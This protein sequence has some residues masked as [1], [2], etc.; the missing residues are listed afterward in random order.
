MLRVMSP[1]VWK[2]LVTVQRFALPVFIACVGLVACSRYLE[3]RVHNTS[4]VALTVC[5]GDGLPSQCREIP[6]GGSAVVRW[7]TGAFMVKGAGCAAVYQAPVPK[8]MDDFRAQPQAPINAAVNRDRLILLI[9]NGV[10]PADATR[11]HQPAGFPVAPERYV[12]ACESELPT[13]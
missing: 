4:G 9:R 8:A 7:G 10:S 11:E 5:G 12:G 6:D 2:R 13:R 1:Q 3:I